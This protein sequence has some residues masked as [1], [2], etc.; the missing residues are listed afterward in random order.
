MNIG[1]PRGKK[2]QVTLFVILAIVI[3]VLGVLIYLF[4]P[5]IISTEKSVSQE[6]PQTYLENCIQDELQN[7][8]RIISENGGVLE[9]EFYLNY[10][11]DK[12]EYL[13]YTNEYLRPCIPQK[14]ML[15]NVIRS[16]LKESIEDEFENCFDSMKEDFENRNYEVN[17]DKKDFEIVLHPSKIEIVSD[18]TLEL[19]KD[20]SE[21]YNGFNLA[22]ESDLYN[23][24]SIAYNIMAWESTYGDASIESYTAFDPNIRIQKI[25][26]DDGSKIYI[27]QNRKTEN[28]FKFAS[29]SMV[30]PAAVGPGVEE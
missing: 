25:K 13:C 23:L 11:G 16:N 19:K 22:F 5:D 24:A 21:T 1:F 15:T 20:T 26:R 18:S 4:L 8:V 3:V 10:S 14:P 12:Y 28:K 6:D 29:R 30:W 17:L 7:N 9:N 2:G 27:I